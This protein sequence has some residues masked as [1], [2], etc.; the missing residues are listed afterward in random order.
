[1]NGA[2]SNN[3][4]AVGPRQVRLEIVL[5]IDLSERR[6]DRR[7]RQPVGGQNRRRFVKLLIGQVQH[8]GVPGAAELDVGDAE[9]VQ[10]RALGR[11]LGIDLV[12][13]SGQGPHRH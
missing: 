8:V 6:A 12:G 3:Q 10:R 9:L 1:M 11:Q 2:P 7:H 5:D 13:E 4:R